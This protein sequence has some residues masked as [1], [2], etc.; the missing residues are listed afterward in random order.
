[1]NDPNSDVPDICFAGT[2]V[3]KSTL[4][5]VDTDTAIIPI[6]SGTIYNTTVLGYDTQLDLSNGGDSNDPKWSGLYTLLHPKDA[7]GWMQL[8]LT[9][10]GVSMGIDFAMK[11]AKGVK[12]KFVEDFEALG[13]AFNRLTAE[14]DKSALKEKAGL[15][16][17]KYK[18]KMDK[19]KQGD[20]A[21]KDLS[22]QMNDA[23]AKYQ[24]RATEDWRT[25]M[26]TKLD[27]MSDMLQK[28]LD[29]G[30]AT[31]AMEDAGDAVSDAYDSIDNPSTADL[32]TQ[33]S[34]LNQTVENLRTS[35]NT[36]FE[37]VINKLKGTAQTELNDAK[38]EADRA[39]ETA[40][41]VTD[42]VD[43]ANDGT[44]PEDAKPNESGSD[45]NIID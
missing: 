45:I 19:I 30:H 21:K 31:S 13:D 6:L 8:F 3:V 10:V 36:Q 37:A 44:T 7:A 23:D 11:L 27:K 35:I 22:D 14:T 28:M 17:P 40:D 20:A 41:K 25:A 29:S 1:V 4:T 43:N 24:D 15:N 5:K 12:D 26:D 2:F 9:F 18:A 39:S 33:I 38:A 32:K 42:D 16:D 34:E